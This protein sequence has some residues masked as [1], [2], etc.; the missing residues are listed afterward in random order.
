MNRLC[1]F[2]P[3][4][5]HMLPTCLCICFLPDGQ[6]WLCRVPYRP[7]I[8]ATP[9]P[10]DRPSFAQQRDVPQRVHLANEKHPTARDRQDVGNQPTQAGR[11]AKRLAGSAPLRRCPACQVWWSIV[12]VI[13]RQKAGASAW[14]SARLVKWRRCQHA[15]SH[16]R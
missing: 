1:E 15:F 8:L 14:T 16:R 9:L 13:P 6:G 3:T 4:R 2:E 12:C 5:F 11:H 10:P 7:D